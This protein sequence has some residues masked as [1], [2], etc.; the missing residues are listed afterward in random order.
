MKYP[1]TPEAK[2][3]AR[4]LVEKWEKHPEC[5]EWIIRPFPGGPSILYCPAGQDISIKV[6]KPLLQELDRYD[7]VIKDDNLI[8]LLQVLRDAVD[9]DFEMP[10]TAQTAT[11]IG[12]MFIGNP[13]I[14]DSIIQ[15]AANNT[16]PIT[17][18]SEQIAD[19]LVDTLGKDFLQTQKD[20]HA[21][22]LELRQVGETDKQS[23]LEKV[24]SE[25]GRC[26]DHSANAVTVIS[27]LVKLVPFLPV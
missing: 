1:L 9:N 8:T 19:S 10:E 14:I 21:A 16:G 23:R 17:Q 15:G 2:E 24:V 25:L 26:L 27:A 4:T 22:I 12:T 13:T 7:L 5:Q 20:L 3:L 18:T 6:T 11:N